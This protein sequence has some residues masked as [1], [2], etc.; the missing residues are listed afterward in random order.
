[1]QFLVVPRVLAALIIMPLLTVFNFAMSMIGGYIV[2][3]GLG[4]SVSFY[5]NAILSAVTLKDFLGGVFKSVVFAMIVAGVGCLRGTQTQSG[6]GAVGDSTTRAVVAGI[7][8]TIV[9]DAVLGV[10]YFNL[11]D[12][13][14]YH[15]DRQPPDQGQAHHPGGGGSPRPTTAKWSSRI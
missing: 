14:G 5:V 6:P 13:S 15:A 11:G 3:G 12:L 9:A 4:Y 2:M 10:L 8:L 1:M 7:V